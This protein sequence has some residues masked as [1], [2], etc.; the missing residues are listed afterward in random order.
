MREEEEEKW[1]NRSPEN[2]YTKLAPEIIFRGVALGWIERSNT[3]TL[4]LIG[5][6]RRH[7]RAKNCSA[8]SYRMKFAVDINISKARD[9]G[10]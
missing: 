3:G 5:L 9:D 8:G 4:R 1:A 10:K 6:I 2:H 7:S